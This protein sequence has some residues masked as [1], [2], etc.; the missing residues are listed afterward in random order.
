MLLVV[1][2]T[3]SSTTSAGVPM[4]YSGIDKHKD[5]CF[6]VTVN[7][8]GTVSL[9]KTPST[10]GRGRGSRADSEVRSGVIL[11]R[12][13]IGVLEEKVELTLGQTATHS[14]ADD[15]DFHR[16]DLRSFT[17]EP[18][19]LFLCCSPEIVMMQSCPYSKFRPRQ[20]ES[21]DHMP[22]MVSSLV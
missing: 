18:I 12:G 9:F 15:I 21:V 14:P 4:V 17:D 19:S 6:I 22:S 11:N 13:K 10:A 3:I 7:E 16:N 5:N 20:S 1:N 2:L 8:Q